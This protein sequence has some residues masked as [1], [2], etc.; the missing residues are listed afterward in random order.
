MLRYSYMNVYEDKVI[1]ALQRKSKYN[2]KFNFDFFKEIQIFGFP[3]CS[4]CEDLSIDVSISNVGLILAKPG[5]FLFS[6]YGQT[7]TISESSYGNIS[8]HTKFQLKAQNYKLAVD[9]YTYASPDDG[10]A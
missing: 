7:Y 4:I 1:S 5:W 9:R 2:S 10:N 3:C 6:G 8:A